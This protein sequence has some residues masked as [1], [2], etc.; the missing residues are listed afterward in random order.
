MKY[1]LIA[2]LYIIYIYGNDYM[3]KL[4][5]NLGHDTVIIF[6]IHSSANFIFQIPEIMTDFSLNRRPKET[7]A[8]QSSH[9]QNVG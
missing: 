3:I 9:E 8:P 7:A 5:K 2:I 6:Y 1:I 4:K